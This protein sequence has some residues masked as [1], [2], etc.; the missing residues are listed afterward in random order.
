MAPKRDKMLSTVSHGNVSCHHGPSTATKGKTG[1]SK[2]NRHLALQHK[3]RRGQ[4]G[5]D[6][7]SYGRPHPPTHGGGSSTATRAPGTWQHANK[8]EGSRDWQEAGVIKREKEH[9]AVP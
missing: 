3:C 5:G 9:S 6:R 4:P 8:T 1:P 7:P 2:G